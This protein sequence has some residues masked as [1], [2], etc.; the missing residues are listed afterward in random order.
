MDAADAERGVRLHPASLQQGGGSVMA[1]ACRFA[2]PAGL[3]MNCCKTSA[4]LCTYFILGLAGEVR[5][6][7]NWEDLPQTLAGAIRLAL[8]F[9]ATGPPGPAPLRRVAPRESSLLR[10]NPLWRVQRTLPNPIP[11]IYGPEPPGVREF[12][13]P[14]AIGGITL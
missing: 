11:T 6:Q 4:N 12:V 8:D 13:V 14:S 7:F 9:E 2:A 3:P 5:S 1:Y 10:W